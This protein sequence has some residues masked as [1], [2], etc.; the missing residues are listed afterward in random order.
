MRCEPAEDAAPDARPDLA[1]PCWRPVRLRRPR[2]PQRA[3]YATEQRPSRS[4][5]TP[6]ERPR[7]IMFVHER[8]PGRPGRTSRSSIPSGFRASTDRRD[9]STTSP[10]LRVSADGT[11]LDWHR[12]PVDLYAFH[13]NRPA[14][15][16]PRRRRLRRADERAGRHDVDALAGG[17]N[18][19]RALLYQDGVDSHQYFVKPSIVLPPGVGLRDRVA[20]RDRAAATASISTVTP[21]DMLVD[22]P[23]DLGRYVRKWDLWRDGDA[24]VQL[25]AFADYPQVLE[26][27]SGL[28]AAYER[29]PA[30]TFAMYGSRHFDDYHALLDA[31]RLGRPR[32]ASSTIS[33][34]TIARADDFLTDPARLAHRRRSR[35]ARVLALVERQVSPAGR[36]DD[37]QLPSAAEDRS[38]V[39]LRRHE[40]ILGDV[41]SFRSGIREPKPYPEYVASVYADIDYETGRSDDADHRRH[42]RRAVLLRGSRRV[43]QFA[44]ARTT[45]TTEGELVWL[46][47]DTIIRQRSNGARSLDDVSPSLHRAVA[48]PAR[49]S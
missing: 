42:D 48:R 22:S 9:R 13:V 15:A 49:W 8:M 27:P 25:D 26:I 34:A 20:R 32:K 21:L 2:S 28:L 29:V 4:C 33:P 38:A 30:E 10:T 19:N 14:G 12:D 41:L 18:W 44:A 40:S 45:S 1:A 43:R 31:Q 16:R 47:V 39:G 37:A 46:D 36:P 7:G 3:P 24:F 5:S 6:R 23:L 11:P 35:H 17:V